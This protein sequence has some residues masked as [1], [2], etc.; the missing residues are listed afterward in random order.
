MAGEM[1]G[2]NADKKTSKPNSGFDM[3]IAIGIMAII[4][5]ALAAYIFFEQNTKIVQTEPVVVW[6][7]TVALNSPEAKLLL[8]SFDKASELANYDV[9]FNQTYN[10]QSVAVQEV[11]KAKQ[12]WVALE[13]A[14][15]KKEVFFAEGNGSNATPDAICF[16]YRTEKHCTQATTNETKAFASELKVWQLGSAEANL[17]QKEGM[18]KLIEAGAIRFNGTAKDENVGA[19]ATK[20]IS[21]NFDLQP[22]T[23]KELVGLGLSPDDQAYLVT[24]KVTYWIDPVTGLV[25]KNSATRSLKS[26]LV[27]ENSMEYYKLSL[28]PAGLPPAPQ[29]FEDQSVFLAFYS[30][31]QDDFVSKETCKAQASQ[32]ERDLCYK[33][34]AAD[35]NDWALCEKIE[36]ETER[37]SCTIIVA[38]NTK[39]SA[40][41]GGLA[42]YSDDCYIA[43]ASENGNYSLC[44]ILK[45]SGLSESCAKAAEEGQKK[46]D[47][48]AEAER[49]LRAKMNCAV[50]TDCA[51]FAGTACAPKNTTQQFSAGTDPLS[52]CY[53]NLSCGCASGFCSFKKN[54]AYYKCVS[55]VEEEFLKEFINKKVEEAN[56]SNAATNGAV[57]PAA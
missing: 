54:D 13:D 34:V 25:V 1:N 30:E 21:Y 18:M 15:A 44:S 5:V 39:N 31:A 26:A 33:S 49:Q 6:N 48:A 35:K 50:D 36:D 28:E 20:K 7:G 12:D 56:S 3:R 16:T 55:A 38:Q 4:V 27:G 37:A 2:K 51:V 11:R 52:A 9:S 8:G 47:K 57:A 46:A 32:Q 24:S 43:V 10:G 45:N 17:A 41:C 53:Q 19:V 29:V 42:G 14:F 40:L 22:L 23:V